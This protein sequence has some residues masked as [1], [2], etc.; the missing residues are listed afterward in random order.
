MSENNLPVVSR[1]FACSP[2]DVFAVLADGWVYPTW[3]VG[4]SRIR[5]VDGHF[6]AAGSQ[7]HHSAGVWPA[8]LNDTTSVLAWEPPRRMELEARGWPAGAAH[9]VIEVEERPGAC[10][11]SLAE[12]VVKGPGVLI[13]RMAR[14]PLIKWR[15]SETLRRLAYLAEGR[16]GR[17]N[18]SG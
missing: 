13:P 15:N 14:E 16:P 9:V 5:K 3:V 4:A 8:L 2:E 12:D 17:R 1:T 7:L 10:H 18:R 11:V 6:P